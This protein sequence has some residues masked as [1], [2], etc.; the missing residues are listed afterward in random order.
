MPSLVSIIVPCFNCAEFLP[1]LV[2][3]IHNQTY[4]NW[5]L[6]LVDDNSTDKSSIETET[7]LIDKYCSENRGLVIQRDTNEFM[8]RAKETGRQEA[9][10]DYM[11]YVDP[12]D[13]LLPTFLSKTVSLLDAEEDI[14]VA[15]TNYQCF[16]GTNAIIHQSDFS[17]ELL[18]RGCIITS[19]SLFRRAALDHAIDAGY[20]YDYCRNIGGEDWDFWLTLAELGYTAKRIPEVL[21]LYRRHPGQSINR[22]DMNCL[23]YLILRHPQL[24]SEAEGAGARQYM[25]YKHPEELASSRP[26]I[27]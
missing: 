6:I 24:Y 13:K 20:R 22:V 15:Y 11:L 21:F 5:E 16:G 12:D 19:C 9:C 10:G 1:D 18:K 7:G 26:L 17:V 25:A 3:S 23:P 27:Q 2:E 14:V 8:T 4:K